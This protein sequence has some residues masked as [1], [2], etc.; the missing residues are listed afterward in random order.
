LHISLSDKDGKI[1]GGH[2]KKGCII[3]TTA[4]IVIGEFDNLIFAR[5]QDEK[6][7]FVEL[8][9]IDKK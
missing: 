3:Y 2:L 9:V 1:I 6:T 5:E 4:E 8:V 7:G